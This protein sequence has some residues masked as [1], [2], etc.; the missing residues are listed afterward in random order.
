MPRILDNYSKKSWKFDPLITYT[1]AFFCE[2]ASTTYPWVFCFHGGKNVLSLFFSDLANFKSIKVSQIIFCLSHFTG[3]LNFYQ[4]VI[5]KICRLYNEFGSSA[6]HGIHSQFMTQALALIKG[7]GL[8]YFGGQELGLQC[9]FMPCIVFQHKSRH[10]TLLF[11]A[12]FQTLTRSWQWPSLSSWKFEDTIEDIG[13]VWDISFLW[14]RTFSENSPWPQS[15][16]RAYVLC[17]QR[18]RTY[19]ET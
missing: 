11:T 13:H 10:F 4:T 7:K 1:D 19:F 17:P 6:S 9:G 8:D 14:H 18:S 2:G 12:S 5:L 15:N 16:L 3:I